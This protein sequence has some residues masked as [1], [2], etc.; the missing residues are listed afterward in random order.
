MG[1]PLLRL[2][3]HLILGVT[4][5]VA[6]V[7][8]LYASVLPGDGF[9]A[10]MLLLVAVLLEVVVL[11]RDRAGAAVPRSLFRGAASAGL[12]LLAVLLVAP[13]AWGGAPLEHFYIPL[14]IARL[15]STTVFDLAIC[16]AV[17]GATAE[18][19]TAPREPAP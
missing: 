12:A 19:L 15:S 17:A 2:T 16:L 14:G 10:G 9:T 1:S 11:G 5:V 3:A 18:A 13:L 8:I 4:W 7:H 6:W